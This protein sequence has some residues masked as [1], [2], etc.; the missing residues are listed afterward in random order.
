M[1]QTLVIFSPHEPKIVKFKNATPRKSTEFKV[2]TGGLVFGYFLS[3]FDSRMENNLILEGKKMLS[4]LFVFWNGEL[5][6]IGVTICT[7]DS[8]TRSK[9]RYV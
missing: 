4:K 6:K 8:L 9:P 5:H 3:N 2:C 1:V 7:N